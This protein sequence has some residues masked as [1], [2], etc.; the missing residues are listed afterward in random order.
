MGLNVE[1]T[2]VVLFTRLP[3]PLRRPRSAMRRV[4]AGAHAFCVLAELAAP[5]LLVILSHKRAPLVR[6]FVCTALKNPFVL[7]PCAGRCFIHGNAKSM[8]VVGLY[9][10]TLA[11]DLALP[12]HMNAVYLQS[13]S[14]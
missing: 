1:L 7:F 6:G 11:S 9:P 8:F 5:L 14:L 3:R 10:C 12:L 2:I 13:L 4:S